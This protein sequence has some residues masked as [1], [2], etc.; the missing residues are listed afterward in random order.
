VNWIWKEVSDKRHGAEFR[1]YRWWGAGKVAA[2]IGY[3]AERIGDR[4]DGSVGVVG[5]EESIGRREKPS[6]WDP[7]EGLGRVGRR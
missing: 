1:R 3:A 5:S 7:V 4:K 2:C 6:E